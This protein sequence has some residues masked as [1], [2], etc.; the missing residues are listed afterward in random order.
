MKPFAAT[1]SELMLVHSKS[2]ILHVKQES[3]TSGNYID[4]D[5]VVLVRLI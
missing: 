5:T 2:H 4:A 1:E 3:E